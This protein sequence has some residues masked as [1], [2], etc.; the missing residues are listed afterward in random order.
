M[1][2]ADRI[3][4]D[5]PKPR[6]CAALNGPEAVRRR[7]PGCESLEAASENELTARVALK[8]GPVKAK[9]DGNVT[10]DRS[11]APDGFTLTGQGA[12]GVAGFAKGGAEVTLEEE[13]V[14]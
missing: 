8:V 13:K 11:G 10:L 7:I 12:G 6:V 5:A 1:D 4:I 2:L 14:G 9:C 3:E